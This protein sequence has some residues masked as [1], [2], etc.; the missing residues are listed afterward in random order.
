MSIINCPYCVVAGG[1]RIG[2]E[3]VFPTH[4]ID[5]AANGPMK[6]YCPLS[7][8]TLLATDIFKK[9]PDCEQ[10]ILVLQR[11]NGKQL[12]A[13]HHYSWGD[14]EQGERIKVAPHGGFFSQV[15]CNLHVEESSIFISEQI[16]EGLSDHLNP[17]GAPAMAALN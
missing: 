11:L 12:F 14:N 2:N 1:C 3:V 16:V 6:E 13:G 5:H 4:T 7:G 17:I 15:K 9:C 8:K 10:M